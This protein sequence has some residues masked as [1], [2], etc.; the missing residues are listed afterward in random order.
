MC[1]CRK[2]VFV[3][4][5]FVCSSC[6]QYNMARAWVMY[7]HVFLNVFILLGPGHCC[8]YRSVRSDVT[9]NVTKDV[10]V[11][12]LWHWLLHA[13][14]YQYPH[15]RLRRLRQQPLRFRR[16]SPKPPERRNET[17]I[18]IYIYIYMYILYT[19]YLYDDS[20]ME[21]IYIYIYICI[22]YIY[23]LVFS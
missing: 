9:V 6:C 3:V 16:R 23:I 12:P 8:L 7:A 14:K 2:F 15:R 19:I 4:C 18:C 13:K 17:Y 5:M 1:S 10:T 21:C 22:P 11:T 20:Y